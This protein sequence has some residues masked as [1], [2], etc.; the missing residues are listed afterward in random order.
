MAHHDSD[1]EH[2]TPL[3][4]Y[5]KIAGGLFALTFLTIIAHVFKQH[6]L[7][8]AP[9]I[10]FAIAAAKAYLVMAYFMHLKYDTAGNRIIFAT[11]FIGLALLFA[12]CAIDIYTRVFQ[13]SIL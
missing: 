1:A 5:L 7:G 6:Y 12:I 13:G 10:A 9:Y 11:G 2:V 3:N 8:L 4:V